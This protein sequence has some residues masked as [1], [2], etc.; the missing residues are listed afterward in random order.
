VDLF[1][2]EEPVQEFGAYFR[3]VCDR[4][5]TIEKYPPEIPAETIANGIEEQILPKL[6]ISSQH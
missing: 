3:F 1:F 4:L 6:N 2:S 5:K